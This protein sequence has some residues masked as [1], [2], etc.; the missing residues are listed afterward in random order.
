MLLLGRGESM[1]MGRGE[2]G[3]GEGA[4]LGAGEKQ[5]QP[6]QQQSRRMRSRRRRRGRRMRRRSCQVWKPALRKP[7]WRTVMPDQLLLQET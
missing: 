4:S 2:E 1:V 6:R 7:G 3:G 5:H